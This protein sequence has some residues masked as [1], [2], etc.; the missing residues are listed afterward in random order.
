MKSLVWPVSHSCEAGTIMLQKLNK[1]L[2][3][4]DAH[5]SSWDM[6]TIMQVTD[7]AQEIPKKY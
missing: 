1:V 4:M 6:L 2:I 5:V 7:I 3:T